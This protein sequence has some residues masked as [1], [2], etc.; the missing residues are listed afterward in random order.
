MNNGTRTVPIDRFYL[1]YRKFD[2]QPD[3]I[4]TRVRIGI[5][6]DTLKLY[7]VSRRKDLDISAFTAA[8][9]LAMT[10][11]RIDRAG[12]AYGGVAPTVIR[13]PRT[14]AFLT[15]KSATLETFEHAG[16]IARDEIKP[17]SDVRGSADYRLQLAENIMAKFWYETF[18]EKSASRFAHV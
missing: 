15:G 9:R 3:E 12:I 7:K 11:D 2:L 4:I 10:G 6:R 13:L 1:G 8:I 17:I 16:R 14:E 18:G 5:V